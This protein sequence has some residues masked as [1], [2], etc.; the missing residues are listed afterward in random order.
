M[1]K[2][3]KKKRR[4]MLLKQEVKVF[5]RNKDILLAYLNEHQYKYLV[6]T[7]YVPRKSLKSGVKLH[8]A[9]ISTP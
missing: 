8:F 6:S 2:R 1:N 7:T 3:Q 5:K 9:K 4:T